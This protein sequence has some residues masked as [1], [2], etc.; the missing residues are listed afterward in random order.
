MRL[1]AR[2]S[3]AQSLSR[4]NL[5]TIYCTGYFFW[6]P[7]KSVWRYVHCIIIGGI[8]R[9]G[10]CKL[11]TRGFAMRAPGTK[12]HQPSNRNSADLNQRHTLL[13]LT[14]SYSRVDVLRH[15][16]RDPVPGLKVPEWSAVLCSSLFIQVHLAWVLPRTTTKLTL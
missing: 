14:C 2:N 8:T 3:S 5:L 12:S 7:A 9:S 15:A 13:K 1:Q 6:C 10:A 4:V 16:E 11:P